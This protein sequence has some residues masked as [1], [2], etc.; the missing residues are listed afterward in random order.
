MTGISPSVKLNIEL[1]DYGYSPE[2]SRAA[3]ELVKEMGFESRV[4][5]T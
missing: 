3:I 2:I 5:I 1:K 4:V